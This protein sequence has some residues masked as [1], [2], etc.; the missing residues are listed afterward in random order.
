MYPQPQRYTPE[1]F[2]ICPHCKAVL[3]YTAQVGQSTFLFL[4]SYPPPGPRP[5]M[6]TRRVN[7][8]II[9]GDVLCP[10]CDKWQTWTSVPVMPDPNR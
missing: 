3:G 1:H 5:G 6:L 8:R 4:Y 2:V 9:A 10:F 7:S